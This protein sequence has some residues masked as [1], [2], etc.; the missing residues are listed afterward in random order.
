[1]V[2]RQL[3]VA[4][5]ISATA[6]ARAFAESIGSRQDIGQRARS[7]VAEKFHARGV[8]LTDSGTS[9]LV[10]A[11]RL[12]VPAGGT[13]GFPGYACVDLAA[14]SL[15]A[16]VRVRLY[17]VDPVTLSPDLESVERLLERGVNAIVVA[18]LFGYPAD[19]HVVRRLA[20]EHGIP[21]IEDAAQAAGASLHGKPLGSLGDLSVLSFGRGK[22]LCAGGGGAVL[23]FD[24]R[25]AEAANAVRLPVPEKGLSGLLKTAVQWAL[26]RPSLYAAPSML[27]WLHLG[28]MVYHAA[29]EPRAMSRGSNA[30]LASAFDLQ[31][32]ELSTRR[33]NAA[34]LGAVAEKADR[35]V[36]TTPI[37]GAEPGYLRY[38]VRDTG[39]SRMASPSLG[40]L[41]P[42]PRAVADQPEMAPAL[43]AGEPPTPGALSLARSLFTLPTHRFVSRTDL[44]R[45]QQWLLGGG[46]DGSAAD[47]RG[48]APGRLPE[49]IFVT[50]NDSAKRMDHGEVG[51]RGEREDR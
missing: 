31:R 39:G 38:A 12:A 23:G 49:M 29:A 18:H 48:L 11:L 43:V 17:D 46:G 36:V 13:V 41:R 45:L 5:P 7:L 35:I 6:V 8:A 9:A 32:D 19:V 28:E 33:R 27:P 20:E 2:R 37:E 3:A 22:G 14:A 51:G 21:V 44:A 30:L 50:E 40:V 1:M 26:G 34:T 47:R 4:S 25:W 16:G 24:A 10:L 15:F 42:Y